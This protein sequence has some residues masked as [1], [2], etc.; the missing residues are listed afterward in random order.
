ML[1]VLVKGTFSLHITFIFI[2]FPKALNIVQIGRKQ[3]LVLL[4]F[5]LQSAS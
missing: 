2:Y 1:I 4:R 5:I 3:S